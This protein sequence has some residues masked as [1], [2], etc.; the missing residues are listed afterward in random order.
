MPTFQRVKLRYLTVARAREREA[1]E[2]R[3]IAGLSSPPNPGQPDRNPV[4]PGH[5]SAQ[6]VVI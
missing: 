2:E 3:D 6:T 5:H 4:S 1:A